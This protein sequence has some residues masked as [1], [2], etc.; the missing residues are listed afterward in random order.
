MLYSDDWCFCR[1]FGITYLSHLLGL[2]GED[3]LAQ[4]VGNYQSALC[5]IPESETLLVW[6]YISKPVP[7]DGFLKNI[8]NIYHFLDNKRYCLKYDRV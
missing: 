2:F 3:S 8:R 7:D 5:N 1:R 4:N 6:S